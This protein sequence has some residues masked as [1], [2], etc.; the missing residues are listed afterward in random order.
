MPT[1]SEREQ[2]VVHHL[3]YGLSNIEIGLLLHISPTTVR[4]HLRVIAAKVGTTRR[5]GIVGAAYR[6]GLLSLDP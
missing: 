3:S 5:A 2:Q 4:S 1:L 6:A